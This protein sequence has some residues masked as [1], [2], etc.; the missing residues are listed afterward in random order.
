MGSTILQFV[1]VHLIPLTLGVALVSLL[2]FFLLN[3]SGKWAT[4][5]VFAF[6]SSILYI[7]IPFIGG[8]LTIVS[9]IMAIFIRVSYLWIALGVVIGNILNVLIFSPILKSNASGAIQ[10]GDYKWAVFFIGLTV[11]QAV[12]GLVV[13]YRYIEIKKEDALEEP[14]EF[15]EEQEPAHSSLSL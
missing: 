14:F 7:F 1:I 3:R 15:L 11:I 5:A 6:I 13:F 9:G 4:A 12:V 8:Y 2:I 10:A